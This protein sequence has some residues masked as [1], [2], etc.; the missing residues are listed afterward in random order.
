VA[1]PSTT[2]DTALG[3]ATGVVRSRD[4][5][6]LASKMTGQIERVRVQ[7]G[8]RVKKGQPLVEMDDAIARASAANAHAALKVAEANL[9]A[10]ERELARARQL[11]SEQ[12]ISESGLDRAQTA[13]DMAAA[14]AEQAHAAARIADQNLAD[15]VLRA[16]FDGTITARHKSAGDTVTSMPV[17]PILGIVDTDHLEVKL[18]VPEAIEGFAR[19]GALVAGQSTLGGQK[20]EAKVRV[21]GAVIDPQTRSVEVLADVVKSEG[22]LRAG[23]VVTV[24]L[25][26]FGGE[27]DVFIP[28]SALQREGEQ[29][30]VLVVASGKA[31]RRDVRANAVHPGTVM[32]AGLAPD[33]AVVVEP[34][35]L[36]AGDAVV[37]LP[38]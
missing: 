33:A 15:T 22:T 23:A 37:A 1:K 24:D 11:H 3:R 12:G 8:D 35:V 18:S 32:V 5:A 10:A 17:T 19:P 27:G 13:R 6:T 30:F 25:G 7:V 20:F 9:A 14:Q 2:L 26:S 31:E 34:G 29:A 36:K 28:A 4:E 16:P 38:E 21:K